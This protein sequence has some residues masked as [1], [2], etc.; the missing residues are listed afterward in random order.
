FVFAPY[1][2]VFR[3]AG[4]GQ[5]ILRFSATRDNPATS[6]LWDWGILARFLDFS[7]SLRLRVNSRPTRPDD[8]DSK[9]V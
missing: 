6:G 7:V 3:H 5:R 1:L 8:Q 2:A 4:T 9:R